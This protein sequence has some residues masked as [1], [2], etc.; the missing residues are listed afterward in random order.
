MTPQDRGVANYHQ[1]DDLVKQPSTSSERI[2]NEW[3]GY[4]IS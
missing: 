1:E 2:N 3:L 4:I